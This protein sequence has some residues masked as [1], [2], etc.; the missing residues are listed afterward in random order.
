MVPWL[1]DGVR[2]RVDAVTGTGHRRDDPRFTEPLAKG[3]DGDAHRVGERVGVAVPRPLQKLLGAED[4]ALCGDEDFEHGELLPGER[5][6]AAVA[7]DLAAER[8]DP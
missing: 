8:V 6:E 3:R 2:R 7:V 5:H 1:R 4:T